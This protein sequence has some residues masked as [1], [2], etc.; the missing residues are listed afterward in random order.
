MMLYE[1]S[2]SEKGIGLC[3]KLILVNLENIYIVN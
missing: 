1:N 3:V 2:K